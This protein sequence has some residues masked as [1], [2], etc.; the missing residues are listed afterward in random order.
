[1]NAP[2]KWYPAAG[3]QPVLLSVT[4]TISMC[5]TTAEATDNLSSRNHC[6][7]G[8]QKSKKPTNSS[9]SSRMAL[10]IPTAAATTFSSRDTDRQAC[11]KY[12]HKTSTSDAYWIL[13]RS[14]SCTLTSM[15]HGPLPS[16]PCLNST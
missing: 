9:P 11:Q 15:V 13:I 10:M 14:S 16:P 5:F 7:R 3:F 12:H 1:M 4:F 6:F 2:G 8:F